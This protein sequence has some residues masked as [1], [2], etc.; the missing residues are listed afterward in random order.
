MNFF[1][2][3][4]LILLG[5]LL[6]GL[7]LWAAFA[8]KEDL[9]DM[10]TKTLEEQ[11]HRADLFFNGV[12][13]SEIVEGRRYWEL[14]AKSSSLN[15]S[16]N[17]TNFS[18][19][20]GTFFREGKGALRILSPTA[21]WD[22]TRKGI[23]MKE[24]IGYDIKFEK[25]F[26]SR[27][28]ELRALKD[29]RAIFTFPADSSTTETGYWFK[30]HS[31]LWRLADEKIICKNGITLTKGNAVIIA[32]RL[33]ADVALEH[34]IL[35]GSPEAFVENTTFYANTIEVD[36]KDN[37]V[38]ATGN[39]IGKMPETVVLSDTALY[40]QSEGKIEFKGNVAITYKDLKGWGGVA[41][42]Y[43][44]KEEAVLKRGAHAIREGNSI[45]GDEIHIFLKSNK[46]S[47]KGQTKVKISGTS[48]SEGAK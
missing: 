39:T 45:K 3:L 6:V 46:I 21:I 1:K 7:A 37:Y 28:N 11:K 40:I 24:P 9:N 22:M 18:D 15:K 26:G 17:V 35:R 12:T 43:I 30:A 20:K 8:P 5:A 38:Y 14:K 16:T 2:R 31:L 34:A 23:Y 10:V 48:T 42:Y 29:T 25:T 33:E 44:N 13:A 41:E 36:N 4:P 47:V 32:D 19:V 27:I